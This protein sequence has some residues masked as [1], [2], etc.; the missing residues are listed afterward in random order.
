MAKN[1]AVIGSS[2]SVSYFKA[3]GCDVYET[4][5]GKLSEEQFLKVVEKKYKIILVTEEVFHKYKDIIRKRTQRTFPVVSIIP[6]VRGA[7]WE[8]G[9]PIPEG[10]A[11]EELRMAVVRAV[12]QDIAS[13]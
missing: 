9:K 13:T 5:G 11:F 2:D 10:V 6:D 12:G 3:I 1:I 7:R 8:A 4:E